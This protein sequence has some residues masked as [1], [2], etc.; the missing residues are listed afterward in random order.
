M[1][2]EAGSMQE[3][4]QGSGS[5]LE[6]PLSTAQRYESHLGIS[7]RSRQELGW[8][9]SY[10]RGPHLSVRDAIIRRRERVTE[11]Q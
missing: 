2:S 4:S 9:G 1:A 11:Q 7:W 8:L 5:G 10:F 3:K 6:Q